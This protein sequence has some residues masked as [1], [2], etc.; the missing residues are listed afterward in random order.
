MH[1]NPKTGLVPVKILADE[2]G[3]GLRA[4]EVRGL[5][6]DVA[7]A[8]IEKKAAEA[9]DPGKPARASKAASE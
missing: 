7:K 4:G 5:L 3:Y 8:M 9:V 2:A 1:V 6:P